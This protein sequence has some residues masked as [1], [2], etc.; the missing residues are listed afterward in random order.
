MALL[1]HTS[2][3]NAS[4]N[5]DFRSL[6]HPILKHWMG[7]LQLLGF[8]VAALESYFFDNPGVGLFFGIFPMI[9]GQL[10]IA[11]FTSYMWFYYECKYKNK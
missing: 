11:S 6:K 5:V 1:Y 10:P 8:L 9:A 7:F 3:A 4:R 2:Y